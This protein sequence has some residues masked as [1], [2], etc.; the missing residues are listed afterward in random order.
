MK[1]KIAL[2]IN[3]L[4]E[5]LEDEFKFK[6]KLQ[7]ETLFDEVYDLSSLNTLLFISFIHEEYG[8]A[9]NNGS[10]RK[11]KTVK[12]LYDLINNLI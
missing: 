8:V 11:I 10:L 6:Q 7:P 3:D 1:N 5:K 12:D 9:L 2:N 4:I